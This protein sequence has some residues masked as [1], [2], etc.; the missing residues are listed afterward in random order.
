MSWV[1]L[2]S[3]QDEGVFW[4]M[5]RLHGED[6]EGARWWEG[7]GEWVASRSRRFMRREAVEA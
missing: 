7:S 1:L 6:P 3:L 4:E 5:R 2:W